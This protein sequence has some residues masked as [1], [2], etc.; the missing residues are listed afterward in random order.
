MMRLTVSD[1]AMAM[2]PRCKAKHFDR[3]TI[4][5]LQ[6]VYTKWLSEN[7]LSPKDLHKFSGNVHTTV[8]GKAR[9]GRDINIT[10]KW[11]GRFAYNGR[12]FDLDGEEIKI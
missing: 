7:N 8:P 5:E 2:G 4:E 9:N 3:E 1:D 10:D 12:L 6:T 11:I